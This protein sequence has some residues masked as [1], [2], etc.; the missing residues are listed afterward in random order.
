MMAPVRFRQAE[1]A[2]CR[3]G[4]VGLSQAGCGFDFVLKF[5][6]NS[7]LLSNCQDWSKKILRHLFRTPYSPGDTEQRTHNTGE[8]LP[9]DQAGRGRDQK[10]LRQ[11]RL[12]AFE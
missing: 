5:G 8:A 11:T 10:P 6:E 12:M 9:C 4:G 1:R 7:V 3:D 2:L